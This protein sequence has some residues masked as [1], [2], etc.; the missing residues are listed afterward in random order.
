MF[1]YT[2]NLSAGSEFQKGFG[3]MSTFYFSDEVPDD[4]VSGLKALVGK[5]LRTSVKSNDVIR[6][7]H[8]DN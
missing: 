6:A 4:N 1:A 2:T 7:S 3:A 5:R 8:F